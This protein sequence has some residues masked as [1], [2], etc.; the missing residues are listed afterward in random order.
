M[1]MKK[2][3]LCIL[4]LVLAASFGVHQWQQHN[5]EHLQ[6]RVSTAVLIITDGVDWARKDCEEPDSHNFFRHKIWLQ[7]L[8]VGWINLQCR[9]ETD[10]AR[11]AT[12]R[13][14]AGNHLDEKLELYEDT[15]NN[16]LN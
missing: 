13:N 9:G 6:E 7:K 8:E 15:T 10:R 1:V 5:K 14:D 12:S 11:P 16:I 3:S 2:V 4:V